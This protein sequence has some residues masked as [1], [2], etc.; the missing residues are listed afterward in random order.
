MAIPDRVTDLITPVLDELGV[1][2][3]DVLHNGGVLRILVTTPTGVDI[4]VLRTVTK[5][6]GH[7]LDEAD[8]IS[9]SYT[10]EVSSPGLERGLRKPEHFAAAVGEEVKL[11]MRP[12]YDGDRR[13]QGVIISAD[14]TAVVLSI[15][16]GAESVERS[17]D[18][19]D[20]ISAKT[21]FDWSP[22]PKPGES[23]K[24]RRKAP[25]A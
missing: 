4:G 6:V 9:A 11:K 24:E 12:G 2:L 5:A 18:Y 15:D 16:S 17:I 14:D 3:Y 10:L 1:E 25:T 22:T 23:D 20:L 19:R 13:L 7:L 21:V 8:P